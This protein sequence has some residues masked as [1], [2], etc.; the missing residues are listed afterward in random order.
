MDRKSFFKHMALSGGAVIS[1]S[2]LGIPNSVSAASGKKTTW[3]DQ[4]KRSADVVIVGG[5]LGGCAAALASLR[6]N[7]T[8]ILTEETDWI[9]G[10]ITQQGVPPDEHPWI[11][12]H[13][14]TRLY[15]DFRNAIRQYYIR[16]YPL[17][18]DAKARPYLN[19]GDGSVSKLCHEP[20]V[21]LA[22]LNEMLAPYISNG[23]LCLL[24][25]HKIHSATL[26]GNR[27]KSL[28]VID[29]RTKNLVELTAPYFVDA[30]ELGD[31]LPITE[32]EFVTGTES[33]SETGEL[34]APEKA[35]H[36]NNQSFT[37]CFAMDYVPGENHII[38]KPHDYEFWRNYIPKMTPQWPGKLLDL[39]YSNPSTLQPKQLGFHP[40][41][42]RTGSLFN[43]WNYRRIINRNNFTPGFYPGDITIVNW[44]QNDYML[45]N[46]IGATPKDFEKHV[47][48]AKQLSLSLL[49][50]LQTE[51]PRPDN[52]K[53]WPGIRLRRDILG[54]EDGL[55]KYPYIRES[56]RIKAAFTVTEQHVG[57]ESRALVTG[58]KNVKLAADFFDSV[59]IGYYHID[60]HPDCGGNNYIDFDSL[61]FQIP[62][63]ALLP[64]RMENLLPANKNIGTTHITNGCYR[65][66]PVEWNIGESVGML[67]TYALTKKVIPK[68]VREQKEMLEEF[69]QMIRSQGIE[70]H[71]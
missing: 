17:T 54:T 52:G 56:R 57:K 16:N 8:V 41:G 19:P 69:Q 61:P 33:R 43:L 5:G 32:T 48:H 42:I 47:N 22:V 13:G 27:V 34:H 4:L 36:E 3:N 62:L 20:R 51:A 23:K 44:P 59:G 60:I 37:V 63:G 46:L 45:G 39:Q 6:N 64:I 71:W 21:A 30:T 70:T 1:A 68:Q 14:A 28:K 15:R 53:G 18:E 31:L 24:P 49:Y 9:G 35:N 50:W 25:E 65:L 58:D 29:L 7:L 40:E 2:V 12:T 67:V 55:A 66:H 11:E 26:D 10:Q 38:E